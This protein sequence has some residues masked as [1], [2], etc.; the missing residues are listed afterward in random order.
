VKR[1]IFKTLLAW[2]R[3]D[4]H[5]PLLLRGARQVGKTYIVEQFARQYFPHFV[6][7][8]FELQ[9]EFKAC[10]NRLDPHAIIT[11]IAALKRQAIVPNETLLFL[12]EIQ[13]CP[14]AIVALRYFKENMPQLHVI[15]AGSLLEFTLNDENLQMPVGRIQ[16]LYV[17]PLSFREFLM[18]NGY[19]QIIDVLMQATLQTGVPDAIHQEL[20][21]CLREYFV[22]GGMPEVVADYLQKKDLI[23]SQMKQTSLLNIYRS[24]FGKYAK[25]TK[26]KYMQVLFDKVPGLIGT[27]IQFQK[28]D[29]DV[30]SRELKEALGYLC[31]AGII[32]CVYHSSASGLPLKSLINEKKFKLIFLDIGLINA[33]GYLDPYLMLN[34]NL[35][36]ANRGALAEQFVGQELL[37]CAADYLPGELFYW[38]REKTGSMAEVD[39]VINVDSQIVPIEVKSG[40]TGTLRS[41]QVFLDEKKLPFGVRLSLKPLEFHNRILSVPLYMIEELPRLVRELRQ[42]IH[43]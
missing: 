40:K 24:D 37:A 15:G 36:M 2:A 30:H 9:P 43:Q 28:I 13:Q 10:F 4:K 38:Q 29:A 14:Q 18:A 17:K 1:L 31:N 7:I 35:M 39:Y 21:R 42:S 34:E 16:S 26:H 20:E 12:D 27:Q 25:Q 33:S 3:A 11:S 8:N 32:H 41:L 6:N 23:Q 19:D 5:D 22:L